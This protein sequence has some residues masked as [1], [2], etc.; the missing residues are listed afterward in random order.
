[1][2]HSG[3]RLKSSLFSFPD[4]GTVLAPAEHAVIGFWMVYTGCTTSVGDAP[5]ASVFVDVCLPDCRFDFAFRCL[6]L[7]LGQ[8]KW[9]SEFM[10]LLR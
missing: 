9:L 7:S 3:P 6:T 1:M 2:F 10:C 5:C 4:E 8:C